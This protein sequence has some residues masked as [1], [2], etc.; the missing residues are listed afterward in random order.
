LPYLLPLKS[1]PPKLPPLPLPKLPLLLPP[2][3]PPLKLPPPLPLKPPLLKPLL[4]PLLLLRLMLVLKAFF[5]LTPD[6]LA[7][8]HKDITPDKSKQ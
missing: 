8:F 3:L 2:K 7:R 5:K 4:P 1:L 6:S